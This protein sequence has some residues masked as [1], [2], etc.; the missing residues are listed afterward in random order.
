MIAGLVLVPLLVFGYLLVGGS[1]FTPDCEMVVFERWRDGEAKTYACDWEEGDSVYV[2]LCA[3]KPT[4][5]QVG[6][7]VLRDDEAWAGDLVEWYW[8]DKTPDPEEAYAVVRVVKR[9]QEGKPHGT[10]E[11]FYPTGDLM[12]EI[13][14]DKGERLEMTTYSPGGELIR[15]NHFKKGEGKEKAP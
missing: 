10:W 14:F 12:N 3:H 8:Y 2:K 5:E 1:P 15:R 11:V 13:V 6:C 4:G 7:W 9:Y